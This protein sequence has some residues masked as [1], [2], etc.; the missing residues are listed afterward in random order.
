L[1]KKIFLNIILKVFYLQ[2]KSKE[3][4]SVLFIFNVLKPLIS[5]GAWLLLMDAVL[6][7]LWK[8]MQS[9]KVF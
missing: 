5:W 6:F 9:K 3:D 7:M 4:L 1:Q 8:P 2:N